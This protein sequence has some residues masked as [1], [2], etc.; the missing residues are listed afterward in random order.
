MQIT[1]S[2][3]NALLWLS[4]IVL[5]GIGSKVARQWRYSG[6]DSEASRASLKLH[7]AVVDSARRAEADVARGRRRGAERTR[8][9][10][11]GR[12]RR[13]QRRS[14]DDETAFAEPRAYN[15]SAFLGSV[16][17]PNDQSTLPLVDVD[18]ADVTTLERLPRIGPALAARIVVDRADH[19]PF[20]SIEG[21]QRVRGVGPK[22]AELLRARVT[23]SGAPRPFRVQR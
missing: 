6:A 7:L 17:K 4:V 21:L 16:T 5:L 20:G 13:S 19:G 2:E 10:P 8:A 23:F 18:V 1:P 11:G 15:G 9:A 12:Q 3:R 22:L 14:D